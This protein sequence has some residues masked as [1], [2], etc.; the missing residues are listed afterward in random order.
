[1]DIHAELVCSHSRYDVTSYFY[2]A[3]I[4]VQRNGRKCRLRRV[5]SNFGG[6]AFCLAQPIGGLLVKLF[7]VDAI[8]SVKRK[9]NNFPNEFL[10]RI[11]LFK[12]GIVYP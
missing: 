2:S 7:L 9:V 12:R 1:M 6:A 8:N 10:L 11:V 3:F 4:G 5:G